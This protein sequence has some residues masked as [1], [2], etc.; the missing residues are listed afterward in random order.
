MRGER[1]K[2]DPEDHICAAVMACKT[3][4]QRDRAREAAVGGC[5]QQACVL[6]SADIPAC[7]LRSHRNCV[8]PVADNIVQFVQ[9]A[10]KRARREAAFDTALHP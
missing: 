1:R 6:E 10:R 4:G 9:H 3:Q 7:P 2:L 8:S 5:T